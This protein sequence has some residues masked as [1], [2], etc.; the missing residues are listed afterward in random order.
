MIKI[1]TFRKLRGGNKKYEI[2]FDKNGKKITRK[3]GA[4]GMSDYTIHKDKNRRERY[5]SRHKKDLKTNDPTKPGYLSMF[6]LWN[7]PSIRSSLGDYKR[8]L[9]VYNRTG[10]FPKNISGSA[11]LKSKFGKYY[12]Y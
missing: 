6:I 11:N 12:R 5:I 2:I 4:S 3:F 7:K 1:V 9:G 8:R 10:R